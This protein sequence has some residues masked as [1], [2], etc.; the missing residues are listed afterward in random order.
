[1]TLHDPEVVRREYATERGLAGRKAAYRFA[2]GPNP[3]DIVLQ[4]VAEAR[5]TR[6][7]EVGCG[8]GELAERMQAEL[9]AEVVALD[10]SERMVE[11]TRARGVDARLGDVQD[12]PFDDG[13]FDCALA[14]WMLYHV[15]DLDR[16]LTE[17][18]RVLRRRPEAWGAQPPTPGRKT[19]SPPATPGGRLVAVTIGLEHMRELRRLAGAPPPDLTFH[20]EN[21]ADL[22]RRHF[23]R[24]ERRDASGWVAF[25][26][27][28]AA[29]EYVDASITWG[30]GRQLP[31]FDGGL[32]VRSA[33]HVFVADK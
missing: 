30:R 33:P 4:A 13:D 6:I 17:L 27:R 2:E 29:Q 21:G 15:P 32:R 28:A 31:Q 18:A 24:V 23:A 10:Q 3:Y 8:E 12:L 1:L 9:G 26:D 22:L 5:P 14:A 11:L 20:A 25:P 19:G 7:L 16:A